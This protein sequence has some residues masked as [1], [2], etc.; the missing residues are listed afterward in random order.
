[1]K[2]QRMVF[3][4]FVLLLFGIG[5][6]I[7]DGCREHVVKA[8]ITRI[9]WKCDSTF[10]I[11]HSL[12]IKPN[13]RVFTTKQGEGRHAECYSNPR[14]ILETLHEDL[15]FTVNYATPIGEKKVV[16]RI[17]IGNTLDK[18]LVPNIG[19]QVYLRTS[20]WADEVWLVPSHH[21]SPSTPQE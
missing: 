20:K 2:T 13:E 11:D 7:H 19:T 12:E 14:M 15:R 3:V 9:V 8:T 4:W 16:W 6:V 5:H 1:M 21:Q 17:Y 10:T 18:S